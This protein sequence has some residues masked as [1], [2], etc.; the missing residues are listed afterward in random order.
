MT[1]P[2][3]AEI[4]LE[5]PPHPFWTV[6]RQIG[7]ER[8]VSVLPR[9]GSQVRGGNL[10]QPWDYKPLVQHRAQVEAAGLE[11]VVIEDNP[12]MHALR[13]GLPDREQELEGVLA[14]VRNLGRLGVP[15]WCYNWGAVFGWTRTRYSVATRGGAKVSGY[16]HSRLADAP[17]APAGPVEAERL[18][19]NLKWFL[20][21]VC[22]VAE[23]AGVTLALH[24]DDPPLPSICGVD[25]II[26][27]LDAF[28]RVVELNDSPANAIAFCQ[29]NVTLMTD[30][31]PA[32]IRRFASRIAYVHFRDV[33]GTAA[34]FVETFHDDGKTDMLACMRAYA[35]IGF[36]G[37]MR[38]DHVPMLEGDSAELPGYSHQARLHAIG[39]MTGL[40]E[41]VAAELATAER[42]DPL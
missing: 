17:P 42:K 37:V 39:Y 11:L 4:L 35:E 33:R 25:R 32:A 13:L 12:P 21:R 2:H 19:A 38:T 3:F 24:P 5:K 18:W 29:G 9:Y 26:T 23:E 31:V 40:R 34:D 16:D 7:V 8:A 15:V 28:D 41:A 30:D 20:D 27:S 22:P 10:E 6:L 14:M 1:L 36:Q